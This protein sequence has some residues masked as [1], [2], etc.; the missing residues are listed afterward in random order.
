MSVQVQVR[1]GTTEEHETFTGAVA[2][3]TVDTTK[4]TLVVHN[5]VTKGGYP[6]PSTK[7]VET[8]VETHTKPDSTVTHTSS[9][10]LVRTV[11]DILEDMESIRTYGGVDD[12]TGVD[13]TAT[14]SAPALLKLWNMLAA[15]NGGTLYL[16][17]SKG[18]T[19]QYF[20][21]VGASDVFTA[22]DK[23]KVHA[24]EGVSVRMYT[25][26]ELSN[27]P[28]ANNLTKYNREIKINLANFHFT[29]Y[30]NP[31]AQRKAS[32]TMPTITALAGVYSRPEPLVGT[33]WTVV[34]LASPH[35]E[36]TFVSKS[37][38]AVVFDGTGKT[39]GAFLPASV[40]DEVVGVISNPTGGK[41]FLGVKTQAGYAY[42]TQDSSTLAVEVREGTTGLPSIILGTTYS[43][44][45]QQRD[46]FNF[47]LV[48]VRIL[49]P[50]KFSVVVNGLTV[51]T[52]ETRSNISGVMLGTEDVAGNTSVAHF[53]RV[54][55]NGKSGSKP[56]NIVTLGDSIYDDAVQYSPFR[57]M[58]SVLQSQ[59][60]QCAN[61]VNLAK[62]GEKAAE[63]LVRLNDLGGQFDFVLSNV[64]VNDQQGSTDFTQYIASNKAICA[65]ARVL[66]ATPIIGIPTMYYSKA[67]A[68]AHG[69]DG[70]QNTG[71]NEGGAIYKALLIRAVSQEGGLLNMQS[72]KNFGPVTAAWLDL[73]VAGYKQDSL[74]VD[75]IHPTP[76]GAILLGLSWAESVLGAISGVEDGTQVVYEVSP[77]SWMRNGAGA[78][79][80]PMFNGDALM[81]QISLVDGPVADGTTIMQLPTY[82]FKGLRR[83]V[84]ATALLSSTGAILGTATIDVTAA[85]EVKVYGVP[86]TTTVL[87]LGQIV[88]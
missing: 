32:E 15:Q 72:I 4:D 64:G 70:G 40:G 23:I 35:T 18:G 73:L 48:G 6:L 39:I 25:S 54:K 26:G 36:A 52:R 88:L 81:G 47:G 61:I 50:R 3:I 19:G 66:G 56:L 60:V 71:N 68:I 7:T 16:P 84:P 20:I 75:N 85:G 77:A 46:M 65:R 76:L 42:A 33:D 21:N 29:T 22:T 5:G 1:R 53:T 2:E 24:D 31:L 79:I 78:S 51:V 9:T 45:N 83:T 74:V 55:T 12:D 49:G 57:V 10:G 87:D 37:N 38:E 86:A 67:E 59:G 30:T 62:E 80:L 82:L 27:N 8:L 63:Q 13:E 43:L 28:F 34:D 44:M 69:Q 14:N 17:K 11:F 41:F 58:Q